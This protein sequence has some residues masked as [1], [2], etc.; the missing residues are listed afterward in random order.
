[1]ITLKAYLHMPWKYSEFRKDTENQMSVT[2][3]NSRIYLFT[4]LKICGR[5]T[6]W[7]T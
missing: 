4:N 7:Y 2:V 6:A 5:K 1:M 3:L